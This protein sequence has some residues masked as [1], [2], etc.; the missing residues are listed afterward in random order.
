MQRGGGRARTKLN[1]YG[2][3]YGLET[4]NFICKIHQGNVLAQLATAEQQQQQQKQ[5]R[6]IQ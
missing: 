6:N 4:L 3:I 1:A 5:H 2:Q